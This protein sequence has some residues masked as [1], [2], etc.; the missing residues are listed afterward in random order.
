MLFKIPHKMLCT[1]QKRVQEASG[2][3]DGKRS[4]ENEGYFEAEKLYYYFE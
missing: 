1:G 2:C 4:E 3:S